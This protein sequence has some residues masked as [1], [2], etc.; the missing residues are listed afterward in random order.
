MKRKSLLIGAAAYTL[1][2]VL[3][4]YWHLLGHVDSMVILANRVLWSAVFTLLVL[5]CT[6]RIPQL[7]AAF[8]DRH[9]R[10]YLL[11]CA[12]MVTSNWGLY[13]WA[14]NNGHVL[15]ASLGYYMNPLMSIA[16]GVIFFQEKCG[17]LEW[18]AFL[19]AVA[20]VI[21]STV[22]FGQ[23]PW[24][25]LLL[26]GLFAA[27][28]A[29]KKK[30]H[31]DAAAGICIETLMM[32]PLALLFLAFAPVSR[33]AIWALDPVTALLLVSTGPVTA[34]PLMLFARG[35]NDLPLSTMG[36]L[37]FILPTLIA[38][39][40]VAFF[41]E[42]LTADRIV[43]FAFILAA[44]ALYTAGLIRRERAQGAATQETPKTPS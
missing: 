36:F 17:P 35:V 13:I 31:L 32:T 28:G 10:R 38:V 5:L 19:L 42:P 16:L 29:I 18:C 26:A 34:L 1:W 22:S 6:R 25:A 21:V 43:A 11:L 7:A 14:V 3:P 27:Y 20:G 24:I 4:L 41:H 15:D 40:G 8:R 39:T 37:Q 9:T 12:V 33:S 2:G 44:L 30:F 23:F